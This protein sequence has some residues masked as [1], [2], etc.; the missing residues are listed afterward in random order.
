MPTATGTWLPKRF[1]LNSR[2]W[3][4]TLVFGMASQETT[5]LFSERVLILVKAQPHSGTKSDETVCCA[6][7]TTDGHWRRQYPVHFRQNDAKFERWD[8]ITYQCRLPKEDRRPESRRV[9]EDTIKVDGQMPRK[10]RASFLSR[11]AVESTQAAGAEGRTLALIRPAKTKFSW[12]KKSA[13]EIDSEAQAYRIATGQKSLFYRDLVALVPCPYGFRFRYETDD[14][15]AHESKCGD[16][17][18]SAMFFN[19]R[20]RYGEAA[21]LERMD[22]V[23]NTEYPRDGM[24]FAMGTHSRYPDSWL[25]VGIIR[26]DRVDQGELP[27]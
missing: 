4:G 3:L 8:W 12:F 26:A 20:Q 13:S 9:Q 11:I 17:E 1:P 21:A 2:Y 25:L 18:T 16:W 24:M 23:F 27:I 7:V 19:L 22:E 5:S 15:R 14:G 10:E 6:G